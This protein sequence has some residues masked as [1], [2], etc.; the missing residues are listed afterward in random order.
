MQKGFTLI[1]MITVII[2][3]GALT[4]YIAPKFSRDDFELGSAKDE[5]VEAIRYTQ[6]M[7]MHQS[8]LDNYQIAISANGYRITQNGTDVEDPYTGQS[9]FQRSWSTI[10]IN[11]PV[12]ITFNSRGRPSSSASLTL[13]SGGESTS[14]T[15][16]SITGYV[17]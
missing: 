13:S 9:P 2:I 10:S 8:S 3:V 7:S 15:I 16:E 17:H 14:L 1:E 12:T 6:L 5:L 11:S 4:A